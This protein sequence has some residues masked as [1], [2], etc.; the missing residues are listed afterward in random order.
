MDPG[1]RTQ[2]GLVADVGPAVGAAHG[3]RRREVGFQRGRTWI[4][5]P[6]ADPVVDFK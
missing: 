5:F 3:T 2:Q 1:G 6:L 4:R